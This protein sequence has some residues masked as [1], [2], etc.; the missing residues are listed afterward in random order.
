M[1]FKLFELDGIGSL[2]VYKRKG[3]STIR[4]SFDS[5]GELRV[6]QPAW[7]PY[8]AALKF[9]KQKIDWIKANKPQTIEL[10]KDGDKL[11]KAHRVKLVRSHLVKTVTGRVKNN[12]VVVSYPISH[13]YTDEI[14]QNKI[15]STAKKALLAEATQLLPY[16]LKELADKHGFSY[17]TVAIK[18][19]KAKWGSCS[20]NKD[21]TLNYYLMQLPWELIDY[22]LL[23]ELVHTE[24]M[25]HG[26][27]FWSRFESILPNAK[28]TRK[29]LKEYKTTV[30]VRA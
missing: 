30:I 16:R 7:L 23:H 21:I 20:Q 6:S 26:A 8:D 1:A 2:K 4:M 15:S 27:D 28:Q 14:V 19:L 29:Q 12:E 25:N 13:S 24:H 22:V 9:V 17:K 5:N 10:F 11:G 3:A 18:Q